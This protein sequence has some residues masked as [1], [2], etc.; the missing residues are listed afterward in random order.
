MV[1]ANRIGLNRRFCNC[2]LLVRKIV[3]RSIVCCKPHRSKVCQ[4]RHPDAE[5]R[6]VAEDFV[7]TTEETSRDTA[8]SSIAIYATSPLVEVD[9]A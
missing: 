2:N 1:G 4:S 6:L 7:T 8:A 9:N 5:N 3:P